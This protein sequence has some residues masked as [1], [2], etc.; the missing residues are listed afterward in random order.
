MPRN[1]FEIVIKLLVTVRSAA[2]RK[3]LN[4]VWTEIIQLLIYCYG[5]AFDLCNVQSIF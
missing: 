5:P 1:I 2:D 4:S 3:Y